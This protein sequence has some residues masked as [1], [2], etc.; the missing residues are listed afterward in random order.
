M[1][2]LQSRYDVED[3]KKIPPANTT[4]LSYRTDLI[5]KKYIANG[6]AQEVNLPNAVT[7]A[8]NSAIVEP[9]PFIFDAAQDHIFGIIKNDSYPKFRLS[10][11]FKEAKRINKQ[12]FFFSCF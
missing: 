4:E 9:N 1:R 2:D 6:S 11:N 3:Y 12:F 7:K 10:E 5:F 8:L